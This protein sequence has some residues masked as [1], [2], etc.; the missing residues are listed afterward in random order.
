MAVDTS[1]AIK[2]TAPPMDRKSLEKQR[3]IDMQMSTHKLKQE[4][5]KKKK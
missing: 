1:K 5:K 2:K 4:L 3:R